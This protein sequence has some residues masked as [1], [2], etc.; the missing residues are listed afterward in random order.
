MQKFRNNSRRGI[1]NRVDPRRRR[2]SRS[3]ALFVVLALLWVIFAPGAGVVSLVRKKMEQHQLEAQIAR[4]KEQNVKLQNDIERL[5]TDPVFLEQ[6]ARDEGEML[7][8][9]ERVFDFSK[10]KKSK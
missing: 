4:I 2:F 8:K 5:Q 3:L 1:T 7:K 10:K 9:N 6:H